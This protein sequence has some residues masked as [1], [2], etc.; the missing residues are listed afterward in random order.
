LNIIKNK[1]LII[2][3]SASIIISLLSLI[4]I[5]LLQINKWLEMEIVYVLTIFLMVLVP[6]NATQLIGELLKAIR[7]PVVAAYVQSASIYIIAIILLFTSYHILNYKITSTLLTT[8][9]GVATILSAFVALVLW[10]KFKPNIKFNEMSKKSS[11]SLR[12]IIKESTPLLLVSA[13]SM[14]MSWIDTIVLTAYVSYEDIGVYSI[15]VKVS[16]LISLV[17]FAVNSV[18]TPIISE[19]YNSN[20]YK[21][22]EF[23]VKKITGMLIVAV[24]PMAIIL[25]QFSHEIM[26]IFGTEFEYGNEVLIVLVVGQVI[27]VICG[28]VGYLLIMT[29]NQIKYRNNVIISSIANLLLNLWLIPIY[30]I[31]GAAIATTLSLVL[32]NF[33]SLYMVHAAFGF[34]TIGIP[35]RRTS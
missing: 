9:Y 25:N 33:L 21:E 20:K 14:L 17:L 22:L 16:L 28:P 34:W 32:L 30:G 8:I 11:E 5:Y 4:I 19:F 27:N 15:A 13:L 18:S 35:P 10:S 7:E 24:I 31:M 2:V 3:I 6:Y 1:F 23:F 26:S 29:N 12:Q